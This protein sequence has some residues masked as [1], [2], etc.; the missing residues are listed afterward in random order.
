MLGLRC[1][2]R[3]ELCWF[4]LLLLRLWIWRISVEFLRT[5][6]I[7]CRNLTR[8]CLWWSY[9]ILAFT[10]FRPEFAK[11]SNVLPKE[12]IQMPS[13]GKRRSMSNLLF[14]DVVSSDF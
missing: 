6:P 2:S 5:S 4:N 3:D 9:L 1:G 8:D 13:G 11:S 14:P 10:G 12:K 7:D